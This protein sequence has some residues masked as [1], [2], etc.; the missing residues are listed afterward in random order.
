MVLSKAQ[1]EFIIGVI[2]YN[3]DLPET[4]REL[5]VEIQKIL[6]SIS[7]HAEGEYEG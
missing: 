4:E 2:E 6:H 5:R 3:F 1:K 7:Q